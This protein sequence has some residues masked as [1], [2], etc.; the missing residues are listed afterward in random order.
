MQ[1][2]PLLVALAMLGLA[3]C[4]TVPEFR[5]LEREVD[6]LKREGGSGGG[7]GERLAELGSQ[8]AALEREVAGLRGELEAAQH[9]ARQASAEARGVASQGAGAGASPTRRPAPGAAA[10]SELTAEV[11][12]YEE[13]FRLY[14][15]SDYEGA[16]DRFRSFL[17]TFPS[18]DYAD[19]ALFWLGEC[20]F[21]L[22]DHEQ[23]V[24]AFDDV[25]KRYPE[26][27][28]VPDA[29]YRQGIALLEI[30]RKSGQQS[31]YRPA[32]RQ[33]FERLLVDYPDSERVAE[34][35]RQLEK[36]GP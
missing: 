8:V 12:S 2:G 30:G 32:A 27:N 5:A 19:N 1:T 11:R 21:K 6:R 20:H 25:V 31:T 23:A 7:V 16:I 34:T 17:H 10:S 36:L 4:I 9:A 13:A 28:K 33:I 29:L 15:A 14:R 24:L 3:G 26:G 35:R 22:G 18:S